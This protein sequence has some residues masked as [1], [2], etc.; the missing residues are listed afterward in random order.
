MRLGER[1]QRKQP[2]PRISNL[3]ILRL[4]VG[5]LGMCPLALGIG[6]I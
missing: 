1:L 5:D 4:W 3:G 2:C 6:L